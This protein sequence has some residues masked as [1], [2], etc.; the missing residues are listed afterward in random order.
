M[1]SKHLALHRVM[2]RRDLRD[3]R[4]SLAGVGAPIPKLHG[5]LRGVRGRKAATETLAASLPWLRRDYS[6]AIFCK[7]NLLTLP[8]GIVL[9][10]SFFF[11]GGGCEPEPH[12]DVFWAGTV[13]LALIFW[14]R[15]L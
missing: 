10:S 2:G 4:F 9:S 11:F 1:P 8:K 14:T 7:I 5:G 15:C 13:T 6:W 12:G 3:L